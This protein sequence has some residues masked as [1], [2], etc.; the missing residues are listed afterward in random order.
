MQPTTTIAESTS[1]NSNPSTRCAP[2]PRNSGASSVR[3]AAT[4]PIGL[5]GIAVR[6]KPLHR[7][8]QGLIHGPRIPSQL[9]LCL[10]A[11][12]VHFLASN[13]HRVERDPRFALQHPA[14]DQRVDEAG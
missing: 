8:S 5:S 1:N 3:K 13:A 12:D 7:P 11:G 4:T 2:L 9:T 10:G 6:P 14:G